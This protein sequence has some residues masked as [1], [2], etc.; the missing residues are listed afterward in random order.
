MLIYEFKFDKEWTK[1]QVEMLSQKTGL[2]ESQVYKWAWDQKKK[3]VQ[4][5]SAQKR[6]ADDLRNKMVF[7]LMGNAQVTRDEFGGYCCKRFGSGE[8]EEE[9]EESANVEENI[10]KLLG[11]D[12]ERKALE[13]VL[14]DI[15]KRGVPVGAL[16]MSTPHQNAKNSQY[17]LHVVST[18]QL[19]TSA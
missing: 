11:L 4:P 14:R 19:K 5:S 9:E 3:F 6:T 1:E 8:Q 7:S 12:I 10:C 16:A 18:P 2:S 13:I 17:D 15:H